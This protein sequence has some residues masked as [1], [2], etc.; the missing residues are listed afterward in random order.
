[1][2]IG[3]VL[4]L[5]LSLLLAALCV[6][7]PAAAVDS[8]PVYVA[9]D[10]SVEEAAD[11]V[12]AA[13]TELA[14]AKKLVL[15][16]VMPPPNDL[17]EELAP[18]SGEVAESLRGLGLLVFLEKAPEPSPGVPGAV[19][20]AGI[21]N[22]PPLVGSESF[23]GVVSYDDPGLAGR[24]IAGLFA[25]TLSTP[26]D[27]HT[28]GEPLGAAEREYIANVSMPGTLPGAPPLILHGGRFWVTLDL[29]NG[30]PFGVGQPELLSDRSGT[31]WFF[32]P[33]NVEML[34]K[35]LNACVEPFNRY[36]VFYAA[37]TNL[38][39]IVTVVDREA[40]GIGRIREYAHQGGQPARPVADTNAFATCP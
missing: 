15:A 31:F 16:G 36:W 28:T 19:S 8:F 32:N 11:F 4:I 30:P 26:T 29:A 9:G 25:R 14:G 38:G 24:G 12:S 13:N 2:R 27:L 10:V 6:A 18:C 7:V 22:T 1:M 40:S 33:N 34:L 23:C 37:T 3:R 39:F 20:Y 21:A 17:L 5:Q 35:V